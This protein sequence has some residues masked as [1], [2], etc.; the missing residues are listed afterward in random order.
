MTVQPGRILM[1]GG[2]GRLGAEL[3]RLLPG[4]VAPDEDVL[5]ITSPQAIAAAIDRHRPEVLLHAAAYTDVSGAETNRRACWAV[6]VDGTKNI[7]RAVAGTGIML[8][9]VSTDYVFDGV[10]GS[11]KEDDPIGPTFNYYALSKLV[12][13]SIVRLAE[14]HLV[15]RTSFREHQWPHPKAF[16]DVFT[17]QD[18]VDIIAPDIALAIRRCREI[19]YDTLHIATERKSAYELAK[20]RRPDVEPGSKAQADVQLPD[21]VSLDVTRWRELKQQW[22]TT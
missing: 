4:V 19:P 1:T 8:V 7:V 17:S 2:S 21:D 3:T 6:N 20:R 14:P 15:I 9:H 18:Y 13:E 22:S 16:T 10:R 11:Y 12:A 5:D